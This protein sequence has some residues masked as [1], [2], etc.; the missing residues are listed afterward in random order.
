MPIHLFDFSVCSLLILSPFKQS[1]PAPGS[2]VVA[3]GLKKKQTQAEAI[4]IQLTFLGAQIYFLNTAVCTPSLCTTHFFKSHFKKGKVKSLWRWWFMQ[5]REWP[6]D[7]HTGWVFEKEDTGRCSVKNDEMGRCCVG[8]EEMGSYSFEK[9]LMGRFSVGKE[10]MRR[11]WVEEV[12]IGRW[13][14]ERRGAGGTVRLLWFF[15]SKKVKIT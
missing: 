14:K 15:I 12:Q 10:E 5:L 9:D 13:S 6:G 11:C 7:T 2:C 3:A 4:S 8:R 1:S